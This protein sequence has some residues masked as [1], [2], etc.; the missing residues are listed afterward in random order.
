MLNVINL[1]CIIVYIDMQF[2]VFTISTQN[3]TIKYDH[4]KP[5][6]TVNMNR[7]CNNHLAHIIMRSKD[8][9]CHA[10]YTRIYRK[11]Q[12]MIY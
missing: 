5:L 9:D 4:T 8:G 6:F 10:S 7:H 11:F 3:M 2:E 12:R 1:V